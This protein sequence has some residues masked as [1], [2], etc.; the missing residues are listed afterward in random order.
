VGTQ[1]NYADAGDPIIE[2][3]CRVFAYDGFTTKGTKGTKTFG[4]FVPFVVK[5]LPR[6]QG[7]AGAR[8]N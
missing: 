2:W 3:R 7:I 4:P 8:E 5:K 6:R 1:F